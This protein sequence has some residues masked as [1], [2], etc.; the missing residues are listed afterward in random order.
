[1]RKWLYLAGAIV[2]EVSG[3]LALRASL[4]QSAWLVLVVIG[5]LMSFGFLAAVLRLGT[6]IGVA[7]GIWGASGVALTAVLAY[8]LFDDP[9]TWVMSLGI[10]VVAAGVLVVEVGSE[11]ALKERALAERATAEQADS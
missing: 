10:V 9:L 2:F 11:K 7:Y 4:D 3:T 5:Y 8:F 1:M 6:P